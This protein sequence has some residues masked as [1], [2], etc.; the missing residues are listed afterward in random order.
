MNGIITNPAVEV[1]S[2]TFCFLNFHNPSL[3]KSCWFYFKSISWI[4][5][6]L[7][8]LQLL[9]FGILL[10]FCFVCF[11][12][13]FARVLSLMLE[14]LLPTLTTWWTH[15]LRLNS[16]F[17][18]SLASCSCFCSILSHNAVLLIY[19]RPVSHFLSHSIPFNHLNVYIKHGADS[20]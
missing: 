12:F 7:F 6:H 19:V 14:M 16:P 9:W 15:F 8:P 1:L 18:Y 17:L 11:C 5:N 4:S 3:N 2:N 13:C 10:V 20:R